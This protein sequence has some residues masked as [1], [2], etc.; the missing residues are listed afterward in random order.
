MHRSPLQDLTL[1]QTWLQRIGADLDIDEQT[2]AL[3]AWKE[4]LYCDLFGL[5]IMG[6]S[7]VG[8]CTSLLRP[9][10][11]RTASDSHPPSATRF[12]VINQV[13]TALDWRTK[14]SRHPQ[15][16]VPTTRYFDSLNKLAS[17]VPR[18]YQ[19]L[20]EA[21]I[22]ASLERLQKF[23]A[24]IGAV[25]C[26][27]PDLDEIA[28]MRN[29]MLAACP[30]V[31]SNVTRARKVFNSNV[32]FRSILFA[33]WITWVST[34]RSATNLDFVKLNMLCQRGI[35]QQCAVDVWKTYERKQESGRSQLAR[36]AAPNS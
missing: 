17:S 16:R 18:R 33:G 5:L 7:Y 26:P 23:L 11:T 35:L 34:K 4:E 12:W 6:P 15:L 1:F 27:T 29:R 3:E 22:L 9:F 31:A 36:G 14:F 8:A 2:K 19:L 28:L 30:P 10:K 25:T 32:D 13:V 20:H 21:Q 24:G